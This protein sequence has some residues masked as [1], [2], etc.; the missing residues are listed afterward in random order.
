[1]LFL[2]TTQQFLRIKRWFVE[3]VP[4]EPKPPRKGSEESHATLRREALNTKNKLRFRTMSW[5]VLVRSSLLAPV[6]CGQLVIVPIFVPLFI[7]L[8]SL[9]VLCNLSIT[10]TLF[11]TLQPI[12][13]LWLSQQKCQEKKTKKERERTQLR[14]RAGCIKPQK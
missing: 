10:I 3:A 9:S 14:G 2:W 8:P 13:T 5:L 4:A 7:W 1:M 6:T 11:A 12:T